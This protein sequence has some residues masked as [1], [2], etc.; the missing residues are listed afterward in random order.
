MFNY[1]IIRDMHLLVLNIKG[2]KSICNT[3]TILK[4][5]SGFV[6]TKNTFMTYWHLQDLQP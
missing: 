1:I 2:T 4:K 6:N 3:G 5:V